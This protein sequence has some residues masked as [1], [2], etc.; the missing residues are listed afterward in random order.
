[1]GWMFAG[2]LLIVAALLG[3]LL[4]HT[5]R[6]RASLAS[7]LA[8][9]EPDAAARGPLQAERD[10]LAQALEEL[11]EKTHQLAISESEKTKSL[12]KCRDAYV[13]LQAERDQAKHAYATLAARMERVLDAD[14]ERAKVLAEVKQYADT[15]NAEVAEKTS[16]YESIKEQREA[17]LKTLE[18]QLAPLRQEHRLLSQEASLREVGFYKTQYGFA[19]SERYK[20]AIDDNYEKQKEMLREKRAALCSRE[21]KL[22]GS[23]EKGQKLTDKYLTLML[24]AFNGECDSVIAKVKPTNYQTMENRIQKAFETLN[25]LG[26]IYHCSISDSY[27][28]ARIEEL[29]LEYEH[30]LKVQAEREEQRAIKE[31]MRQQ[32]IAAREIEKAQQEAER[33]ERQ[34]EAAL[35]KARDEFEKASAAKQEEMQAKLAELEQMVA[36]AHA[37]KERA[38]SRAQQTRSGHV[39]VISNIGSFGYNV[40]KIGMT[41]RLDP[42]D[43][44]WELSDASVPFDFDVHAIIYTEDAPALEAE[45]HDRFRD[46]RVNAINERKEYFFA[47]MDEIAKVV[48]ERFGDIELTLAAEAA[49]F[50]QSVAFHREN[51]C[52]FVQARFQSLPAP[53]DQA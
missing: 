18:A 24:R 25:K 8:L 13:V 4:F 20:K 41:R 6:E 43:R 22:D 26:E 1:M 23:V 7:R 37:N 2:L 19:T 34:Y 32:A 11:R 16:R 44:I 9:A 31:E 28:D 49:E 15:F 27:R 14:A 53:G 10:K 17:E 50:M 33:E 39:Y 12:N 42:M 30:A 21:W 40:Y 5:G 48:R 29:G 52:Q 47:T 38:V 36:E 46:R 3:F 51:G 35:A 45:L